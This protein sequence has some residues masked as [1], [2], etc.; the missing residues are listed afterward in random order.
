MQIIHGTTDFKIE[1]KSAV[2]IG[3]FD[4]IHQGHQKL[5]KC[6]L[7]QSFH[8]MKSV[9]FTF[10]PPPSVL[11]G[12]APEK[13]LMTREEKRAAFGKMG[14]DILIE[15]PLT[16]ETAAMEPQDF[17]EEVLVRRM[18]SLSGGIL[19]RG[20]NG[21]FIRGKRRREL[22]APSVHGFLWRI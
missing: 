22:Y 8:G 7:E 5:L 13:E 15:F 9:V 21:C 3:K 12:T 11:F 18:G 14:I 19:Y 6:I 16:F 1:G 4:G 20:R 10:D 17:I 2:A